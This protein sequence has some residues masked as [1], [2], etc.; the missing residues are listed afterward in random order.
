MRVK[1]NSTLFVIYFLCLFG[2][3]GQNDHNSIKINNP[4]GIYANISAGYPISILNKDSREI[5]KNDL[6]MNYNINKSTSVSSGIVISNLKNNFGGKF[7]FSF[8]SQ[9]YNND[10]LI[11]NLNLSS[12]VLGLNYRLN[13]KKIL[14]DLG[15]NFGAIQSSQKLQL[16]FIEL[17]DIYQSIINGKGNLISINSKPIFNFVLDPGIYYRI[18]PMY[19]F[20]LN[21][22]FHLTRYSKLGS[23]KNQTIFANVST[24]RFG[25]EVLINRKTAYSKDKLKN[26][27][28]N[29][30]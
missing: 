27:Y 11:M 19:S 20:F 17:N 28:L 23:L 29:E 25:I 9:T 18:H 16:N 22:E 1:K 7:N 2:V 4:I 3:K 14:F 10:S 8:I 24:L 13:H 15:L 26:K 5:I 12:F 30:H 21:Y 6:K